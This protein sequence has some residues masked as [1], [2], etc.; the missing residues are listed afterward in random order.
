MVVMPPHHEEEQVGVHHRLQQREHRPKKPAPL[1][2][3]SAKTAIFTTRLM[4]VRM[5]AGMM[6][7]HMSKQAKPP[8]RKIPR[9]S[10]VPYLPKTWRY[11][12]AQRIRWCQDWRNLVG[13]SS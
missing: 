9:S 4:E 5:M 1:Q 13:C 6:F 8:G 3:V 2:K 11:P 12:L 7:M 10:C